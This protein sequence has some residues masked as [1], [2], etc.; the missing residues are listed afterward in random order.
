M[1][2]FASGSAPEMREQAITLLALN[3]DVERDYLDRRIREETF[4]DYS[5]ADIEE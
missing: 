2:Q 4:G 1:G 5:L 3:P